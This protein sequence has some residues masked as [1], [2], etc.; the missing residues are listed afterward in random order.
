M[1]NQQDEQLQLPHGRTLVLSPTREHADERVLKIADP[2]GR[3]ELEIELGPRGPVVRVRAAALQVET[4]GELSLG[5]ERFELFAR[6]GIR[7]A[8]DGDFAASVAGDIDYRA[9][10][11]AHWEGKAVRLRA[12]RGEAQLEAHDDVRIEGERVLLNS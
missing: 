9:G 1:S 5:C 6:E 11:Q 3:V 4:E 2:E 10:G 8:S 12:R 7:V